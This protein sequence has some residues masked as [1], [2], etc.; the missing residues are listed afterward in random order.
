MIE[1][2]GKITGFN[3]D[4]LLVAI[5]R[6][7]ACVG[8]HQKAACLLTDCK[9]K[10]I[11]V[12]AKDISSFKIG[13]EVEVCLEENAARWALFFAFVVP[14]L[15]LVI[16]MIF[17]MYVMQSELMSALFSLAMV[18]VYYFCLF[19]CKGYFT[20]KMRITVKNG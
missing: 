12:E 18:G 6:N 11:E 20:K 14:L 13:Q 2:K 1:K 8:C 15:V 3:N 17:L 4:K 9:V 5:E 7:A 16:S 19:L 10:T